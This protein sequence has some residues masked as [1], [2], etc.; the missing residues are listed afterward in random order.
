MSNASRMPWL[1]RLAKYA[2]QN[3]GVNAALTPAQLRRL[4]HKDTKSR[5][6]EQAQRRP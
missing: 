6:D 4:R 5:G 1:A 3:G 2:E